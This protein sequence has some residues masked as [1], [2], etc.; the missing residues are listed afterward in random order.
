METIQVRQDEALARVVTLR[1]LDGR[2]LADTYFGTEELSA[3]LLAGDGLAPAASLAA[4]WHNHE[5]GEVLVSLDAED[6]ASLSRGVYT[7]RL[8][9]HDG[10]EPYPAWEARVEVLAGPGTDTAPLAYATY[11]GMLS[12]GGSLLPRLQGEAAQAGYAEERHKAL[13]WTHRQVRSR[14]RYYLERRSG[15]VV[16]DPE[17]ADLLAATS[18]ADPDTTI[19]R[20]AIIQSA[21]DTGTALIVDADILTANEKYAAGLVLKGVQGSKDDVQNLN[22]RGHALI[23]E[24]NGLLS[25]L[26]F[27]ASIEGAGAFNLPP[28]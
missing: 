26:T 28:V 8:L 21:L 14:A 11:D 13:L 7:A 24:A 19:N 25:Q 27:A 6:A 12:E 1:G 5:A 16:V 23:S 9:I 18:A 17:A 15:G 20:L 3:S 2:A 10:G 22:G 4:A